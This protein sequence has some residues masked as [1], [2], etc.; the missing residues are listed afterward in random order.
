MLARHSVPIF[1]SFLWF[2]ACGRPATVRECEEIVERITKL[3]LQSQR[4][5]S[6][7]EVQR[8]VEQAKLALRERMMKD[9]VGRRVSE[10]AMNCLRKAKSS[11]EATA[12]FE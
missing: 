1:V 8:E 10:E 4:D 2:V 6:S 9:C 3:E 12:C 7:G 5:A 11:E